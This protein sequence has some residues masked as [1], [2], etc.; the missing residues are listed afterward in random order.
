MGKTGD[1]IK[2]AHL[3]KIFLKYNVSTMVTR[4][5][6]ETMKNNSLHIQNFSEL[7]SVESTEC[8]EFVKKIFLVVLKMKNTKISPL[9]IL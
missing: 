1:Q 8:I 4:R 2:P 6:A 7:N 5:K 9:Q 3:K